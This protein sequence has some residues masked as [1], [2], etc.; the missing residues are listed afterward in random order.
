MKEGKK[1]RRKEGK[2]ER[3]YYNFHVRRD[4]SPVYMEFPSIPKCQTNLIETFRER[5]KAVRISRFLEMP[6]SCKSRCSY[7]H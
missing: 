6:I 7:I 1:E 3:N 4:D 2:K 5:M